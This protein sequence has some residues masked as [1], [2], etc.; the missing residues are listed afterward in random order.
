MNPFGQRKFDLL[1]H[2]QKILVVPGVVPLKVL[3]SL[4]AHVNWSRF[5][6]PKTF[7]HVSEGVRTIK[8]ALFIVSV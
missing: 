7:C 5:P 4:P 8:S 2:A 1:V 3:F 6:E